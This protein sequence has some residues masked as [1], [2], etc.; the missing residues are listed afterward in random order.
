MPFKRGFSATADAAYGGSCGGAAFQDADD[1]DLLDS[2]ESS[3]SGEPDSSLAPPTLKFG[4][5][6]L[7]AI[8]EYQTI[9]RTGVIARFNV[10]AHL[11]A[12]A[13]VVGKTIKITAPG[14]PLVGP[15]AVGFTS[16][17]EGEHDQ[18]QGEDIFDRIQRDMPSSG[19]SLVDMTRLLA[20]QEMCGKTRDD[21]RDNESFTL[22]ATGARQF[23]AS[24]LVMWKHIGSSAWKTIFV[25]C[26]Y[27]EVCKQSDVVRDI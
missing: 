23:D 17:N 15:V 12:R 21:G 7:G 19:D 14:K 6:E 20:L 10:P 24:S 2:G 18:V 16:T 25:A 8:E 26:N 11:I 27:V 4:G 22:T 1:G 9:D 5:A 3:G 13:Q